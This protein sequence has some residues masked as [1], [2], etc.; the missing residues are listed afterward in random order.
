MRFS[1]TWHGAAAV[2]AAVAV[3]V[4]GCGVPDRR[5]EAEHLEQVL[6]ALPGTA[7]TDV[8]YSRD[9]TQGYD[10]RV[11]V[12]LD[13]ESLG[14][15]EHIARMIEDVKGNDFEEFDQRTTFVVG[16]A[17]VVRGGRLDPPAVAEDVEALYAV[18]LDLP[19]AEVS[20]RDENTSGSRPRVEVRGAEG[21]AAFEAVRVHLE[22]VD[23]SLTVM[24]EG[25]PLWEVGLPL[26]AEQEGRFRDAAAE[27]PLPVTAVTIENGRA[28]EITVGVRNPA[29]AETDLVTVIDVLGP[30]PESPLLLRWIEIDAPRD[31]PEFGGSV[32]VA[33]CDYPSTL[34]EADPARFYTREAREVGARLR[35]RYDLCG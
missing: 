34:G 9:F 14:E 32:H 24:E 10:L 2:L 25:G 20:W 31:G 8:F 19:G 13:P 6:A 33:G 12:E 26:S 4:A 5:V 15:V 21:R 28:S 23:A 18:A 29:T 11:E 7:R 3:V 30:T 35:E 17:R 1:R 22:S 16:A 27:S